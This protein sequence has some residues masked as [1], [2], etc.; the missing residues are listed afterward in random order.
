MK[1][2]LAHPDAAVD[3]S[4]SARVLGSRAALEVSMEPW[5]WIE[6]HRRLSRAGSGTRKHRA[7]GGFWAVFRG[8][9]GSEFQTRQERAS[10]NT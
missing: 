8:N 10:R 2:S 6:L 1:R 3:Q 7:S 5:R 4:I 9:R